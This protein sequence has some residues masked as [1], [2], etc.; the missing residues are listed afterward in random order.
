MTAGGVTAGRTTPGGTEAGGGT[1]A[2]AYRPATDRAHRE[3]QP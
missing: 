2:D 3:E 1:A